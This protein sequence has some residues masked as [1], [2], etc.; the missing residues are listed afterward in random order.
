MT[1][2]NQLKKLRK[3]K[4]LSQEELANLLYVTRQ[5]V[6]QWENDKTMPSVDLLVKLSEIFD[7]TVDALLGK[8]E[9][10]EAPQPIASAPI[11]N[12]KKA[13][14]RVMRY[15]WAST[16]NTLGSLALHAAAFG[17][18]VLFLHN[19]LFSEELAAHEYTLHITDLTDLAIEVF[20]VAALCCI[21]CAVFIVLQIVSARKAARYGSVQHGTLRFYYDHFIIENGDSAPISLFYANIRRITESDDGFI[22]LMQNKER[23]CVDKSALGDTVQELSRILRSANNY[24]HVGVMR[25]GENRN[26]SVRRFLR[27]FLFAGVFILLPLV[28]LQYQIL[29][30]ELTEP[31]LPRWLFAVIPVVYALV[32]AI[33]GLLLRLRHTKT[34][35]MVIAGGIAAVLCTVELFLINTASAPLYNWQN[36]P[37]TASELCEAMAQKGLTV[38]NA[39]KG[40]TELYISECYSIHPENYAFEITVMGFDKYSYSYGLHSAWSAYENQLTDVRSQPRNHTAYSTQDLGINR[41]YTE[42]TDKNYAYL[43][44]NEY[45]VIVVKAPIENKEQVQEALKEF[46]L[47]RPY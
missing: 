44:L 28:V 11:L 9:T 13:I 40:R 10:D 33:L 6:S 35:R 46:E 29:N 8:P 36:E 17:L 12:D 38:D 16:R 31:Q 41:F 3:E 1:F 2:G 26:A 23:L 7:T 47:K 4:G 37:V 34:L 30:T 21:A 45:T 14:W 18:L 20:T 42:T 19:S 22:F 32:C 27:D 15:R 24:R 5:S 39:I 43:S 25:N